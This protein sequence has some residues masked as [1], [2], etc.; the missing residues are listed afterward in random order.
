MYKLAKLVVLGFLFS[1]LVACA[2]NDEIEQD[3]KEYQGMSESALYQSATLAYQKKNYTEAIKK[4]EAFEALFPFSSKLQ[5]AQ[6]NTIYSYLKKGDYALTAAAADRY[7]KLYPRAQHIDYVYYL[8]GLANFEQ[9][10]GILTKFIKTE[11]AYRAPG[12]QKQAYYDFMALIKRF[13]DSKYA[14]DSLRRMIYLRNQFAKKQLLIAEYYMKRKMYV[15]A[16]NRAQ[17]VV[18]NYRQS[19]QA[20]QA[21][22]IMAKANGALGLT[23]AKENA[24]KVLAAN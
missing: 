11:T 8:R 24:L 6:L 19:P 12:T 7:I 22:E 9:P 16:N 15:A 3:N 5:Q 20:R 21:L 1:L 23:K 2:H 4:Y 13:P 14:N 10:R 17:Y 18:E